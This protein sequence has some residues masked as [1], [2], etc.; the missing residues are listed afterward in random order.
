MRELAKP[1]GTIARYAGMVGGVAL[2]GL[3]LTTVV[4]VA[5]RS[6]LNIA[7]LG[8]TE[9]TELGLVV[10]AVLGIAF[11]GWTDGHI[12]LEF[13]ENLMPASAWRVSNVIIQVVSAAIAGVVA[14]YSFA[15]AIAVHGRAAHTNLL[16]IPEYPFYAIVGVGFLTYAVILLYKAVADRAAPKPEHPNEP[17][18]AMYFPGPVRVAALS[19]RGGASQV[20]DTRRGLAA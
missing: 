2:L 14:F 16:Q 8:V 12:A 11:C 5:L 4:D 10:V 7:F 15:E 1:L 3:M 13:G 6:S 17:G 9:I 20:R 19:A 18:P